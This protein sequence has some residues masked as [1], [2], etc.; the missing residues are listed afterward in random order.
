LFTGAVY[1]L[2]SL[3]LAKGEHV[4]AYSNDI[5]I[6]LV[7]MNHGLSMTIFVGVTEAPE[8]RERSKKRPWVFLEVI[9]IVL[10]K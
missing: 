3:G 7:H 6:F 1:V 10:R 8:I 5:A 9:M 2:H 4:G